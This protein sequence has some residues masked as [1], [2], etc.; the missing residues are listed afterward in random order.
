MAD[1]DLTPPSPSAPAAHPVPSD[2]EIM[3]SAC[4]KMGGIDDDLIAISELCSALII[5]GRSGKT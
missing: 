5:L 4:K 2:A 1:T 3:V